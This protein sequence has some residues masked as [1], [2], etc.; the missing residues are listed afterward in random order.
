VNLLKFKPCTKIAWLLTLFVLVQAFTSAI[1]ASGTTFVVTGKIVDPARLPYPSPVKIELI[2]VNPKGKEKV[3]STVMTDS[4]GSFRVEGSVGGI[5]R[6][7]LIL[8]PGGVIVRSLPI[9]KQ[10]SGAK[11]NLGAIIFKLT[12]SDP[13]V[14]CDGVTP[15]H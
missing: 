11:L 14:I 2:L 6:L 9:G 4:E 13:G 12:C 5:Y 3:V 10:S 1:S 7:K 15:S 8:Q